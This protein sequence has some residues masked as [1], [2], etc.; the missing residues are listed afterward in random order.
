LQPYPPEN[1]SCEV[2][3]AQVLALYINPALLDANGMP[4]PYKM[5]LIS[6]IGGS[7]YSRV[8]ADIFQ[9]AR[10]ASAVRR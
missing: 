4:D 9:L 1:P 2:I 3:F 8:A 10:P 5:D 7:G 6:R